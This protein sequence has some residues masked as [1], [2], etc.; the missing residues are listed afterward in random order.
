MN[1][2]FYSDIIRGRESPKAFLTS[3]FFRER[4]FSTSSLPVFAFEVIKME[5]ATY[6]EY[7]LDTMDHLYSGL[8]DE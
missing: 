5:L 6:L 4:A 1:E 2:S 3:Y 8:I 7:Y